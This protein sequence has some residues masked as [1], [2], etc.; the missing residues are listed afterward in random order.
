MWGKRS[1]VGSWFLG[2]EPGRG[3]GEREKLLQD[4]SSRASGVPFL[5]KGIERDRSGNSWSWKCPGVWKCHP[6]VS[7]LSPALSCQDP[8]SHSL[9]CPRSHWHPWICEIPSA[10]AGSQLPGA[11][12]PL[13][14]AL[15]C[16][17]SSWNRSFPVQNL[18]W[19]TPHRPHQSPC[20]HSL[21]GSP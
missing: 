18:T 7:P 5:G 16:D 19:N 12:L 9:L 2:T 6:R 3:G 15:E 1:R 11:A 8:T 21:L 13:E 4:S 10:P 14:K 20:S 17:I